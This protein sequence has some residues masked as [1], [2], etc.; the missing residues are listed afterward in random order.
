MWQNICGNVYFGLSTISLD[1]VLIQ[2]NTD[3]EYVY[4]VRDGEILYGSDR[5]KQE[6]TALKNAFLVYDIQSGQLDLSSFGQYLLIRNQ[7][8]D[9]SDW[10]LMDAEGNRI[11]DSVAGVSSERVNPYSLVYDME[12]TDAIFIRTDGYVQK[13]NKQ[14]ELVDEIFFPENT[15]CELNMGYYVGAAHK[16]LDNQICRGVISY[17]NEECVPYVDAE[18]GINVYT[19][20]GIC[21][22]K[23]QEDEIPEALNDTFVELALVS[24]DDENVDILLNYRTGQYLYNGPDSRGTTG[25]LSITLKKNYCLI[26][27]G[28]KS[29][30]SILN[31]DGELCY[32]GHPWRCIPTGNQYLYMVRGPY[33]GFVDVYGNWIF[34]TLMEFGD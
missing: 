26:Q 21:Y 25:P 11:Y 14:L 3:R 19:P 4:R 32:Q 1:Q 2:E 8:E 22:I 29:V 16:S 28:N 30:Y 17:N 33:G 23:L 24:A 15:D 12:N 27:N 9:R 7:R 18:G 13:L 31:S 20:E 6:L 34:K 5:E 10:T